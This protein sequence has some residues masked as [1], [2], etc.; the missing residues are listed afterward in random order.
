MMDKWD[1]RYHSEEGTNWINFILELMY[2]V[3]NNK[4][5]GNLRII[6]RI[7]IQEF[8]ILISSNISI[9]FVVEF[10]KF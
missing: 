3:F 5:F 1:E 7:R 4:N 10:C 2:R 9:I 8:L 6:E